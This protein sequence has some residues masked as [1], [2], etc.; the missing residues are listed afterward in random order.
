MQVLA[1]VWGIVAFVG[2]LFAMIP[3]LGWLNWLNIP[4]AIV[5]VV[6]SL[7]AMPK[8]GT[9]GKGMATAGLVLS[10]LAVAA[11]AVRLFL[12]GGVL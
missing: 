12:G 6:I 5:G 7:V 8:S 3:C 2:F 10:V 1:L 4:M 9:E 11:G